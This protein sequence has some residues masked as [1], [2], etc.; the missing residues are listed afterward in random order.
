MNQEKA[1]E[2]FSAYYEETLEAGL[3][4]TFEQRLRADATLQGEYR[5]FVDTM[6]EL[7]S[8][9]LEEIDV[10]IFLSDRIATRLE[11]VQ[12][13]KKPIFGAW[14]NWARNL[15]FAG[16]AAAA[17]LGTVVTLS[18]KP[19]GPAQGGAIAVSGN[20][21]D[22]SVKGADVVLKYDG[23]ADKP[24]LVTP[25]GGHTKRILPNGDRIVTQLK[26][27][28]PGSQAF[29]V[30]I[31]GEANKSVIVVPGTSRVAKAEGEGTVLSFA[32]ALASHYVVP[33]RLNVTKED[34]HLTWA[35]QGTDP[36]KAASEALENFG[37]SVDVRDGGMIGILDR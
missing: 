27:P 20:Q 33:V 29:T 37:Y 26:N 4:Q 35:L 11:Q 36:Q 28:N 12:E 24:L 5:A 32:S 21:L 34:T 31:E 13:Q 18:G 19:S 25:A 14:T 23:S 17:V 9:K 2:F 15:S 30:Q 1:R 16:L 10:P 7:D 22:F 8:L 6:E 3:R